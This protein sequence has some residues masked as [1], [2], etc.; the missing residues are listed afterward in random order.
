MTH[1]Q[2]VVLMEWTNE[3]RN[4]N[5]SP[6]K[7]DNTPIVTTTRSNVAGGQFK[8]AENMPPPPQSGHKSHHQY[9][10]VDLTDNLS[11]MWSRKDKFAQ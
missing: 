8:G 9:V 3:G 11:S 2:M 5:I 7:F 10:N 1:E 4:L 6:L